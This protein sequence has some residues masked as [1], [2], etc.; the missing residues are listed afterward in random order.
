MIYVPKKW[1]TY[2]L[3]QVKCNQVSKDTRAC[4]QKLDKIGSVIE[5]WL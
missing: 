5:E 1:N 2:V 4:K 3:T